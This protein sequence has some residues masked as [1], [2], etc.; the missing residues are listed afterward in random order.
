M[1]KIILFLFLVIS[2]IL[3]GQT[4]LTQTQKL[5]ATCKFW[6]YL[7][8]YH[9]IVASGKTDWDQQLFEVLPQ[10]EKTQT[11]EEFSILLEKWIDSLGIIPVNKSLTI[12]LK[13]PEYFTKNLDL[14][15]TQKNKLFSKTL[16]Q[17]LQFITENRLQ[18]AKYYVTIKN[19]EVP[20][21]F[22]NE[23][24]YPN[25]QWTNKDLR[26]LALFR[27]WNY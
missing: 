13:S 10:I 11:K 23:V 18:G 4:Q 22:T 6:G 5:A 16:L 8:Y 1:K 15:W 9:P 19:N 14:S 12:D 21:E 24:E 26:I 3:F 17:K 20:L 7:K 27:Y 25:F 2:P